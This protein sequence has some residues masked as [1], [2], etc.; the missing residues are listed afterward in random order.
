[1]CSTLDGQKFHRSRITYT[2]DRHNVNETNARQARQNRQA[3]IRRPGE[4]QE[5]IMPEGN[6]NQQG[7]ESFPR[8]P[9]R[10]VDPPTPRPVTPLPETAKNPFSQPAGSPGSGAGQGP[11]SDNPSG[12]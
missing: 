7:K 12:K 2:H 5:K 8:T 10:P 11:P 1:V 9:G 4:A 6:P 3:A